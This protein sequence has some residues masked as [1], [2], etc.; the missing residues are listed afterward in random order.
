MLFNVIWFKFQRVP[1]K[2]AKKLGLKDD[3]R[4]TL[5]DPAGK[6]WPVKNVVRSQGLV[7]LETRWSEVLTGHNFVVGDAFAF[8]FLRESDS[9]KLHIF[10]VRESSTDI[11]GKKGSEESTTNIPGKNGSS[12]SNSA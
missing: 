6:S 9:V 3:Q 11:Q 10:C 7:E 2:V 1:E 8:E 5:I 12:E 4:M